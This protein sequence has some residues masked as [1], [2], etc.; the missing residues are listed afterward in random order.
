MPK[1]PTGPFWYIRDGDKIIQCS[2]AA[3]DKA[4]TEGKSVRYNGYPN[5]HTEKIAEALE[6][7]RMLLLSKPDLPTKFR[8]VLTN[9]ANVIQLEVIDVDDPEFWIRESKNPKYQNISG[10]R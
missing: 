2:K 1:N 6:A 3:F 10:D 9:P 7:S 4:I 5:K 8:A